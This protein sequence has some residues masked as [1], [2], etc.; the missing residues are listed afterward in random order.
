MTK[1]IVTYTEFDAIRSER[2][3]PESRSNH[4]PR[5]VINEQDMVRRNGLGRLEKQGSVREGEKSGSGEI[6]RELLRRRK[7]VEM[8]KRVC[9]SG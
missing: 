5:G 8:V 3:T 9:D 7:V 6:T 4:S 1:H 2:N